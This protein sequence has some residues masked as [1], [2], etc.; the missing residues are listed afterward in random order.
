MKETTSPEEKLL[1]LIRGGKTG[2]SL[3]KDFNFLAWL[4][5]KLTVSSARKAAA[6]LFFLSVIYLAVSFIYPLTGLK[7]INLPQPGQQKTGTP[8]KEEVKPLEFYA[9]AINQRQIF[10]SALVGS[11]GQPIVAAGEALKDI[12]LVGV[13][14]GEPPQAV[15]EDK[16]AQR[17]YYAIKGQSVGEYQLEDIQDGKVILNYDGKKYELH[18]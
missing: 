9:Q 7:K 3:K 14:S 4:R 5:S 17:T 6:V 10:G 18:I 8:L 16:K 2:P 12:S 11:S 15:I 1:R 13:I